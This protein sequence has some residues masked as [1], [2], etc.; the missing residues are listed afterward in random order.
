M[1]FLLS[2]Y[3]KTMMATGADHDVRALGYRQT[4][5]RA[6]GGTFV[7]NVGLSITELVAA[8]LEEAAES[9]VFPPSLLNVAGEHSKE[10]GDDQHQIGYT[11][12]HPKNRGDQ[13]VGNE[14][15]DDCINNY[16]DDVGPKKN[17]VE[18]VRSISSIHEAVQSV[19]DLSHTIIISAPSMLGAEP[20]Y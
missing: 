2:L 3:L 20:F 13:G 6:A 10:D 11:V 18:G 15:G 14:Q 16:K 19:F 8:K 12:N 7:I 4:K 5:H 17:H 1:L 9:L